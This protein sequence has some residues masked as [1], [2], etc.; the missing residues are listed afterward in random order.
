[1][2]DIRTVFLHHATEE[3]LI[4]LP[5]HFDEWRLRP[6][7]VIPVHLFVGGWRFYV[8]VRVRNCGDWAVAWVRPTSSQAVS[9]LIACAAK[10]RSVLAKNV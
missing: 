10:L 4:E 8:V 7:C 6:G 1:M 9:A 2:A 5:R 3:P